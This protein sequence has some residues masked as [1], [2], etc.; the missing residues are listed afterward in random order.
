MD[1]QISPA[2]QRGHKKQVPEFRYG[3]RVREFWREVGALIPKRTS[4]NINHCRALYIL[5]IFMGPNE[6][7]LYQHPD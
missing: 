4:Q 1:V 6:Q 5:A 3:S 2:Y 7:L